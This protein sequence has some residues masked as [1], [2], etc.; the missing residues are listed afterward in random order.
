MPSIFWL[1]GASALAGS[2]LLPSESLDPSQGFGTRP[3]GPLGPSRAQGQLVTPKLL[4]CHSSPSGFVSPGSERSIPERER[5]EDTL[6]HPPGT[7]TP[8]W[9]ITQTHTGKCKA[10]EGTARALERSKS[11]QRVGKHGCTCSVCVH[12]QASVCG[13]QRK[14]WVSPS[15]ALLCV[16]H[17]APNC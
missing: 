2:S 6:P 15:S 7:H 14:T 8:V 12:T 11:S 13:S 3:A 4:P 1:P 10:R 16:F 5:K 9:S 17:Q